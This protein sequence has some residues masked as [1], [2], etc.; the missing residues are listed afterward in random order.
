MAEPIRILIAED[1]A[2]MRRSLGRLLRVAGFD[3]VEFESAEALLASADLDLPV[4]LIA[5]IHLP[6]LCGLD[7]AD[8]LR[9]TNPTMPVVFMT[10]HDT[11]SC[12]ERAQ[13]YP[14]SWYL[15]KPFEGAG[16][17]TMLNAIRASLGG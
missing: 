6:G 11:A 3:C 4:C 17:I 13:R 14:R 7:L 15:T 16:L 8:R 5:D 1:D 12:R 9:E 10:A 2:S